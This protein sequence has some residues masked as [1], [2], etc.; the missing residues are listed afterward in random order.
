MRPLSLGEREFMEKSA[1]AVVLC[2][3][4]EAQRSWVLLPGLEFGDKLVTKRVK[5]A[6]EFKALDQVDHRP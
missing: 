4:A 5:G 6:R 2:F 3:S 1:Y